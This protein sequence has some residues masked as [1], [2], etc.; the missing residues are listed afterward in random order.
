MWDPSF[1]R[2]F[3]SFRPPPR[4][5]PAAAP[6]RSSSP[7][8]SRAP[9]PARPL[10]FMHPAVA[11]SDPPL[12]QWPGNYDFCK[13]RKSHLQQ[14]V[15]TIT[16]T[17]DPKQM[18]VELKSLQNMFLKNVEAK[19]M[20]ADCSC[21]GHA[22]WIKWGH[23]QVFTWSYLQILSDYWSLIPWTGHMLNVMKINSVNWMSEQTWTE[24]SEQVTEFVM[25][26]ETWT[27]FWYSLA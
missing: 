18:N 19:S 20:F 21:L 26:H 24:F 7:L 13:T 10:W 23:I 5:L 16:K 14:A 12:R 22:T 15:L 25:H 27:E 1:R 11:P 4:F 9:G 8:V 3:S 6:F 17:R 2:F